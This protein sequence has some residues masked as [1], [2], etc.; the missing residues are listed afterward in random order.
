MSKYS[1]YTKLVNDQQQQKKKKK[2]KVE[3]KVRLTDIRIPQ[4]LYTLYT[5]D[6]NGT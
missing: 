3:P 2:K 4:S 5:W 6:G 1:I